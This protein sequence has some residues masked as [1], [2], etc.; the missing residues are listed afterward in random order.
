MIPNLPEADGTGSLG[1]NRVPGGRRGL[2]RLLGP[3]PARCFND[4]YLQSRKSGG[5]PCLRL[6]QSMIRRGYAGG[7]PG[8]VR[9]NLINFHRLSIRPRHRY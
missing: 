7:I 1:F 5:K 9:K 4:W 8:Q 6:P 3:R 2:P